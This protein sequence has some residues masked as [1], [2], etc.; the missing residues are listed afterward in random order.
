MTW[1]LLDLA[2][3]N[4]EYNERICSLTSFPKQI[5]Y[6]NEFHFFFFVDFIDV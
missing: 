5:Y 6:R 1:W 2:M 4:G 3:L